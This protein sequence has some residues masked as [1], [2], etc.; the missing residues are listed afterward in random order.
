MPKAAKW[1]GRWWAVLADIPVK[2]R[3][4][5]DQF[6][7]K[8]K[9]LGFYPLQ[10]TVWFYPF[11]PRDEIDFVAEFYHVYRFVTVIRVD[12][13]NENDRQTLQKYFRDQKII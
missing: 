1:D 5:A 11:D 4:W 6:R 13:L 12:K 7:V 3:V 9:T 2:D 10:R 8:V